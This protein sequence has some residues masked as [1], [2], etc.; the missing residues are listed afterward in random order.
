M[1]ALERKSPQYDFGSRLRA[2]ENPDFISRALSGDSDG[3]HISRRLIERSAEWLIPAISVDAKAIIERVPLEAVAHLYLVISIKICRRL[4]TSI[5]WD[6]DEGTTNLEK[7]D[8][9]VAD[10]PNLGLYRFVPRASTAA[11]VILA[12]D[13][14]KSKEFDREIKLLSSLALKI[15]TLFAIENAQVFSCI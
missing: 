3:D 12:N 1:K 6:I 15:A 5:D 13:V 8:A 7:G 9:Y 14:I 10:R 4:S 11:G 2:W